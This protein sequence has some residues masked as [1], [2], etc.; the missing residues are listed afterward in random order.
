[1]KFL[2]L[3]KTR[4]SVRRYK[5]QKVE[6][7]KLDLILEAGR[8]A[9]T[10]C[11]YQPQRLIVVQDEEHLRKLTR[12]NAPLAFIVCVDI[13]EV[14]ERPYD[15]KKSTDVDASII[16]DH[17]MLQYRIRLGKHLAT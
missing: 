1:M 4:Y 8:V 12:Y 5:N 6:Q 9:P 11:N 10:A 16:T 15:K 14:W 7:E 3:A 13:T 17:M 2:D